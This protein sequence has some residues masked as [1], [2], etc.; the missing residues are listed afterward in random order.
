MDFADL[1][2]VGSGPAAAFAAL[3]ARGL[4]VRVLDVG[5]EPPAPA[6]DAFAESIG[7]QYE[8]LYNLHNPPISLKLKSPRMSFIAR[9]WQQLTPVASNSFGGVISLAK[10]GLANGWGAGVYRFTDR[11]LSGFPLTA[12]E[13]NPF[14]EEVERHIGICG[15]NDDLAPHFGHSPEILP[16]LQLTPFFA[17]FLDRYSRCRAALH[18]D[19]VAIGRSRLAVL[20]QPHRGRTAYEYANREFFR[21]H[22]PAIYTPAYTIDELIRDSVIDYLP[23]RLVTTYSETNDGVAVTCRNLSTGVT[24]THRARRLALGAGAINTARIVLASHRDFATH[25][26][27]YDNPMTVVPFFDAGLIGRPAPRAGTSLAQLNLI[28]DDARSPEPLQA[29]LY[30]ASGPLRTDVLFSLPFSARANMVVTKY[31]APAMG[32]AMLFFPAPESAANYLRL[33][34]S[35]ALEIHFDAVPPHPA[36]ARLQRAL[37]RL[38]YLT[39]ASLIQRPPMGAGLHFAGPLPMSPAPG[40]YQTDANGLLAGARGVYVI[41]GAN[42]PRLP[43]KNLTLTIMANAL[44]IGRHLASLI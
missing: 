1:I 30:G 33:T 14:Y 21:P 23:H 8:S 40:R 2:I 27:L 5:L 38:G 29:S 9:N 25:L 13:L 4:H 28:L 34:E 15:A 19:G 17:R 6:P 18:R 20:T 42:F 7:A 11:D 24:E 39:H 36:A 22:D 16:P 12:S 3:G 37:R 31:L 44:R 43:A 35:G 32:V 41:D 26:P 10:G